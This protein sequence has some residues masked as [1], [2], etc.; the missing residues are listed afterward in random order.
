MCINVWNRLTASQFP[1]VLFW[2]SNYYE[3]NPQW[4]YEKI[5]IDFVINS[6]LVN[7]LMEENNDY[8]SNCL[9][10]F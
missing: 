10:P 2:A 9:Y 4:K 8:I 1:I 5:L 3:S 6:Y 7:G